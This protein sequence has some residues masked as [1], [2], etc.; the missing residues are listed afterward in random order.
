MGKKLKAKK[1]K[2]RARV[3]Y[4]PRLKKPLK[5]TEAGKKF[6]AKT[7]FTEEKVQDLIRRG[8]LRGF[9]TYSE[10]LNKFQNIERNIVFLEDLYNRLQ[11]VGVDV[12]EGKDI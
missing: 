11:E 2:K 6:S 7:E 5:K 9:V 3:A 10:I 8:K 4:R 1:A 12:V